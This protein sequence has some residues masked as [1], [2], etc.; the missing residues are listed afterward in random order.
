MLCYDLLIGAI[1]KWVTC[2]EHA[3]VSC[4]SC[5]MDQLPEVVTKAIASAFAS[6]RKLSWKVQES[7]KVC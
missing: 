7:A 5:E 4:D 1:S 6:G 3:Q 2:A